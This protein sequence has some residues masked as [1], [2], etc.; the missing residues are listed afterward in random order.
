M[1]ALLDL[2]DQ[3]PLREGL[4]ARTAKYVAL[5]RSYA[6]RGEGRPA[7]LALWAADVQVLQVLLL[8]S[9]L[10]SA[11]DPEAQ[12]ALVADAVRASLLEGAASTAGPAT[13]REVAEGARRAMLATFDESV[14]AMLDERFA[15]LDHLDLLHPPASN[16]ARHAS[17][18]PSG[19]PHLPRAWS[20]TCG[21]RPGTAWRSPTRWHGTGTGSARVARPAT[22]TSVPSRRTWC[23]RARGRRHRA[24]DRRPPLGPRRGGGR[25]RHGRPRRGR[26][27]P[28]ASGSSVV[29]PT[30]VA[31]LR[32]FFES[33]P[34]P[35]GDPARAD[36]P[37]PRDPRRPRAAD[38]VVP[39]RRHLPRPAGLSLVTRARPAPLRPPGPS[40]RQRARPLLAGAARAL[41]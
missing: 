27:R 4:S 33:A 36:R 2:A 37:L 3:L 30:E 8:E 38:R 18:T 14:H 9:G 6:A 31:V 15:S 26:P 32:N 34:C 5:F 12:M 25:A 40:L 13:L 11:P 29:G 24:D 7:L 28:R 39:Q 1:T 41:P 35:S 17:R 19:R 10:E 21:R 22:P 23:R 16:G 20:T